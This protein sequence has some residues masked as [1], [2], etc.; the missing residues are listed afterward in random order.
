[1]GEGKLGPEAHQN[2]YPSEPE[3]IWDH[4]QEERKNWQRRKEGRKKETDK[5]E[6]KKKEL[7][8]SVGVSS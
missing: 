2:A 7:I 1:M 5:E 8:N 3:T 4:N 6:R